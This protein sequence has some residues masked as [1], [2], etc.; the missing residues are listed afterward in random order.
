M[1]KRVFI[2]LLTLLLLAAG[3]ALAEEAIA[4][5][6]TATDITAEEEHV[7]FRF[8]PIPWDL[9]VMPCEPKAENYLPDNGG[10]HDDSLDVRIE[11]FRNAADDTTVMAVYIKIADPTQIRTAMASR[12]WPSNK[13]APVAAMVKSAKGV[14][15]INGDYFG[16]HAQGIVVRNTRTLR[17]V[18]N[19]GRDTLIIDDKG[20]FTILTPTTRELYES[21]EGT[22]V[23]AFCFGPG[24]VID[25][26]VL[27]DLDSLTIDNGKGKKTQRIAIGQTGPLEYLVLTCEGPENKGSVGMNLLEFAQL[28]SDM[29]CINA[30]NLD[31]GSSCTV[32]MRGKKINA[33]SSGKVRYVSDCIYFATLVP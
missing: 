16:Y 23:H 4:A 30:Y 27:D 20:D 6:A 12:T 7:G 14:I 10:Y 5:E 32:A 3:S 29:G 17:F 2:M 24:L 18:P 31:G 13:T 22:V 8:D 1:M 33:L 25:G 28:C 21:F 19:K 15:G 11:T 26:K 9:T